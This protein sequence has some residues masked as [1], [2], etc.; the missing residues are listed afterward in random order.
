M[1]ATVKVDRLIIDGNSY[2]ENQMHLLPAQLFEVAHSSTWTEDVVGF[3][4]KECP[5]SNHHPSPFTIGTETYSCIE[6]HLLSEEALLFGAEQT[7]DNIRATDDPVQML[8]YRKDMIKNDGNYSREVWENRAP[9]ILLEGLRAKFHQNDY[10]RQFLL[11][12][13]TRTIAE[14]SPYDRFFGIGYHHKT[15]EFVLQRQNWGKNELGKGLM[16]VRDELQ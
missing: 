6:E 2:T 8:R 14:A 13:G 4:R 5:L 15:L 3:F 12:T 11:K 7:A 10:C 1:L 9:G 16:I